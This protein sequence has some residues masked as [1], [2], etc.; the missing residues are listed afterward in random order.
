MLPPL[1][2]PSRIDF[3]KTFLKAFS[4]LPPKRQAAAKHAVQ[5]LMENPTLPSLRLHELKGSLAGTYSISAGGDLRLHF[6]TAPG[7]VIRFTAIGTHAQ[8]YR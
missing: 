2:K 5:L 4:K 1:N 7:N 8:L 6:E 3:S